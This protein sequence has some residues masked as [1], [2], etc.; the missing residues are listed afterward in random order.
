LNNLFWL[1]FCLGPF[2]LGGLFFAGLVNVNEAARILGLTPRQVRYLALKERLPGK[3]VGRDWIF[4][5]DK[6]RSITPPTL[7]RGGARPGSGPKQKG[8]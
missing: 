2:V 6:L 8:K 5:E 7:Q 4:D 3:K 1:L